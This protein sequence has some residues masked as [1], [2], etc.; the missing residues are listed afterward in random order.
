M[1]SI[2]HHGQD[3][4]AGQLR[5][6]RWRGVQGFPSLGGRHRAVW[7]PSLYGMWP[8]SKGKSWA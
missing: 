8:S 4:S 7:A 6:R 1:W 5:P 3:G 2:S